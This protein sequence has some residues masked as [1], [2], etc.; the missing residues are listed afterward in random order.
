MKTIDA[1]SAFKSIKKPIVPQGKRYRWEEIKNKAE[2][3]DI[4]GT[5]TNKT[6]NKNLSRNGNNGGLWESLMNKTDTDIKTNRKI[7]R[8][9]SQESMLNVKNLITSSMNVYIVL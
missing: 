4:T 3:Y 5:L 2:V 1:Y 7:L 8:N 9:S 6:H